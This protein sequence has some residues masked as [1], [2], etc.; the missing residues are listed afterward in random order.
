MGF[1]L[2]ARPLNLFRAEDEYGGD[3]GGSGN[4]IES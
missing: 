2:I 3:N 4:C 1:P